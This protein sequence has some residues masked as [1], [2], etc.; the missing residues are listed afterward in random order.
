MGERSSFDGTPEELR[1][2]GEAALELVLG[3]IDE[4]AEALASDLEGAFELA[5]TFDEAPPEEPRAQREV[6]ARVMQGAA[7][8]YDTAGP[9]YLAYIPGGGLFASAVAD[10]IADVT[11]RFV[12]MAAP[13]PPFAAMEA[14]VLRWLCREFDLP[15]SALGVMTS[16]GSL[17][18]FSAV[19]TARHALLPE[20]FLDGVIY[21]SEHVH[22]S[23]QKAARL[24]GFPGRAV[25]LVPTDRQL[26]MD[27]DALDEMIRND[28]D[29]GL[30]PFMVIAS[31]G[32]TNTGT[33]DPL[34]S[35][36]EIVVEHGLWLHV[37]AAYGG[38]F[39]LTERGRTRFD[40][41]SRADSITLDP[42]KGMFLPYG[43]GC[44]LVRDVAKLRAAHRVGADYLKDLGPEGDVPNFADLSPDLSRDFRGLRVWLPLQLHGVAAWRTALDE[45]LDLA[46]LAYAS[47]ARTPGLYV[48]WRPDLSIVAFAP[49]EDGDRAAGELLDRVNES[50]RIFISSTAIDGRTYL[51]FCILS[52]RTSKARIDEAIEIVQNAAADL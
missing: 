34:P 19:V 47:L 20:D 21:A 36:S 51:R 29:H 3:F 9:G 8:A 45:K 40:G 11:N 1:D 17:A 14:A 30:T 37:D 35:L 2:L 41:I 16:G 42:H 15:D 18:N 49:T 10:L 24:A 33:I 38:F 50:G 28:R 48:P 52:H 26:R 31:A 43:L 39:Q 6:L 4:R 12:N 46:E 32:T 5:A 44:L 22:H 7:K 13:A 23:V 25:R 27:P